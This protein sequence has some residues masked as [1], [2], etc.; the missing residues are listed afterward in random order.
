M[1][2]YRFLPTAV[3]PTVWSLKMLP[4][5]SNDESK[6]CD[7]MLHILTYLTLKYVTV[8]NV[9]SMVQQLI[10]LKTA[11]LEMGKK[12]LLVKKI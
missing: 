3:S 6:I 11:L 9:N 5:F 10:H 4:F 7:R 2:L 8:K 12:E 1:I